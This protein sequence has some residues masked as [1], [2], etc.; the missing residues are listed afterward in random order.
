MAAITVIMTTLN[1]ARF[2]EEA[3]K[4]ILR[5]T[6]QDWKLLIIDGGS[7]DDTVPKIKAIP[8][9]RIHLDRCSGM[10]RSEQLNYGFSLIQSKYIAIMDSDDVALPERLEKEYQFLN[11]HTNISIVGSWA[12]LIDEK[13]NYLGILKKPIYHIDIIDRL[14]INA[15]PSFGSILFRKE[16]FAHHV[17]FNPSLL[18]AEDYDWYIRISEYAAMENIP[19]PLMRFR[20]TRDS[21]SRKNIL[22]NN[23]EL[24][25]SV[26]TY[27]HSCTEDDPRPILRLQGIAHYYY[28]SPLQ[29]RSLLMR[30]LRREG[31]RQLTIRYLI[32]L[33]VL[34]ADA[35]KK[36]RESSTFRRLGQLFRELESHC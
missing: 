32:P 29:A 6:F 14:T 25:K 4:S 8:D 26:D 27:F 20:Q 34:S 10:R 2:V 13:G 35:F 31:I 16:I 3:I 33:L 23:I 24:M 30:S 36:A 7:I 21:L 11:T 5:Q 28:G 22:E 15:F 19:I 1:S 12:E 9:S 17:L 18:R